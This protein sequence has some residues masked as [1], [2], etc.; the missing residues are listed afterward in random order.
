M[1]RL[2]ALLSASHHE[3]AD[4]LVRCAR[5]SMSSLGGLCGDMGRPMCVYTSAV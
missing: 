4:G 1:F 5:A 2:V 3:R